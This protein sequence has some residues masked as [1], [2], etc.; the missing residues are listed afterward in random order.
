MT[1]P[2]AGR[3]SSRRVGVAVL[4]AVLGLQLLTVAVVVRRTRLGATALAPM[5]VDV[6]V[7]MPGGLGRL[8]VVRVVDVAV[9]VAVDSMPVA[10]ATGGSPVND[11]H[12]L[13]RLL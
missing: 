8:R 5:A 12:A 6:G 13:L 1:V 4:V 10:V 11:G 7:A 9:R 2:P 3:S